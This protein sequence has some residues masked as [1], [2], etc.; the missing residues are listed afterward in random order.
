MSAPHAK[1]GDDSLCYLPAYRQL[2]LFRDKRLSPVDVLTAQIRR[3][4]RVGA[5]VNA[6][7]YKHFDEAIAAA[8]ESE[9]RYTR[10]MPRALA[11]C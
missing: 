3:I 11:G 7:T 1:G 9:A 4:E 6:I 2:E 8:R 5:S 10:G